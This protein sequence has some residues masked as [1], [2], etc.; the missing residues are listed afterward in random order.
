[1]TTPLSYWVGF[2][3]L[4]AVML[5]VEIFA[6]GKRGETSTRRAAMWTAGWVAVAAAFGCFVWYAM[7]AARATEFATGYL[8]EESLSVDNLFIFLLLFGAFKIYGKQQRRVLFW[9]V[10]GAVVMRAACVAAGVELLSHFD[11][12]R[13]IFAVIILVAAVRLLLPT[14]DDETPGW[15]L[16]LQRV[17]PVSLRQ[18]RFFVREKGKRMITVL[19]LALVSIE[20]ADIVFAV[21]S[22][23]AVLSV[24]RHPFIAYTSNI[25]AVMGLRSLYFVLAG[26]LQKLRLLHY[27]LAGVLAF[28]G[29]KMLL[30]HRVEIS[31][32]VSLLVIVA[33]LG[34]TVAAS[35]LIPKK[36]TS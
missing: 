16:W 6:S 3:L 14:H 2:H 34:V 28:V 26:A 32:A 13:I 22:I 27:G 7:G 25:M 17:Q 10:L 36:Q 8:I 21:D 5:G 4:L 23:P 30:E 18:D 35:L 9:G 24:T 15:L 31:A 19:L 20:L 12:M 29:I 1:M 11:W 33:V